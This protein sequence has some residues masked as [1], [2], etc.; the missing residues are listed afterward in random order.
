[1]RWSKDKETIL[2]LVLALLVWY[3]MSRQSILIWVAAVLVLAGLF[4][5]PLSRAI[6]WAWMKLSMALGAVMSRVIL[7]IVFFL[8]ILP[9]GSI[10]RLL[11]K[12]GLIV[13][14]A[15]P[16]NFKEK[17]HAFTAADLEHPW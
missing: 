1:M 7:T 14:P 4:V 12:N 10:S 11:G 15:A 13:D 5:P 3:K 2:V 8:V 6:H 17:D 9:L 16:S